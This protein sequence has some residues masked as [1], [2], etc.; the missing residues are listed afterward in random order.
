MP[1]GFLQFLVITLSS[2][3]NYKI[4]LVFHQ[5]A[6]LGRSLVKILLQVC[7]IVYKVFFNIK[8]CQINKCQV[9]YMKHI[10]NAELK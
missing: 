9:Q 2:K 3:N 7:I 6:N 8:C 10:K 1:L 4:Y 5:L